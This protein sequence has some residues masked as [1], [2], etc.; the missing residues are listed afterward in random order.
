M[1]IETV[2]VLISLAVLVLQIIQMMRYVK[3]ESEV[4]RIATELEQTLSGASDK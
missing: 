3:L 4:N 2:A 1:S